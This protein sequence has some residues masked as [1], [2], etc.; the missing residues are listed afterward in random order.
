[1][2]KG[3][4]TIRIHNLRIKLILIAAI[5]ILLLIA[6]IRACTDSSS[7][8]YTSQVSEVSNEVVNT[9]TLILPTT[10]KPASDAPTE[11]E[12]IR[13]EVKPIGY[14]NRIF[15]DLNKTHLAAAKKYGITPL[16]ANETVEDYKN[17]L[18]KV[19]TCNEYIVDKLTHSE[20]YLRPNAAKLLGDIGA[21][22]SRIIR[23]R[24]DGLEYKMIVTSVLRTP[25]TVKAL[26][27]RNSNAT[28]NSAH[29]YGTTFDISYSKFY[30]EELERNIAREDLKNIL[31]EVIKQMRSDGRC[32]VKFEV[33][34]G[35]FHITSRQ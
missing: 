23:E 24:S 14:L 19:Q 10:D 21:E 30:T 25:K 4:T 6:L 22:F 29:L 33:K 9:S 27:R 12:M 20:P 18:V 17:Q 34:Q 31:G 11:P 28:T 8:E 1:M 7:S 13:V 26:Q 35:C 2:A 16:K 15:K 5:V 32:Y 3:D